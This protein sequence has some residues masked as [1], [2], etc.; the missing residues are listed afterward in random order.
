[1][2]VSEPAQDQKIVDRQHR[3]G[4]ALRLDHELDEL[5]IGLTAGQPDHHR[6]GIAA[7]VIRCGAAGPQQ[8][9]EDD[10]DAPTGALD[11][12][13]PLERIGQQRVAGPGPRYEQ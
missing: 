10:V 9:L 6:T 7:T 3:P 12:A 13:Y 4:A 1:M 5:Q 2:R 8:S 11:D